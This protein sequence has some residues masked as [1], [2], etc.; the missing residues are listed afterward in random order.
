MD[1]KPREFQ[2]FNEGTDWYPEEVEWWSMDTCSV[3]L[4]SGNNDFKLIMS[5]FAIGECSSV[6]MLALFSGKERNNV[7]KYHK[8]NGL[9]THI[10]NT[11]I[12]THSQLPYTPDLQK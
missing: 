6:A 8:P 9:S 2:D 3:P 11:R 1:E 4:L 7:V 5:E 10:G 12:V